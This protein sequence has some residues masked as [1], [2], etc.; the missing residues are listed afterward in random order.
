MNLSEVTDSEL[1]WSTTSAKGAVLSTTLPRVIRTFEEFAKVD[2]YTGDIDPVYWAIYSM[3]QEDKGWATRFAV[4]MLAYYHTGVAA[5]AADYEGLHFWDHLR[6]IYDGAPRASERRHFRG[7]GGLQT[8]ATMKAIAPNPD[9]FFDPMPRTYKGVVKYCGD[10]LFAFGPYFQLKICD[11]MDRCLG[12]P[13]TDMNGLESNLPTLPAKAVALLYPERRIPAAFVITC[14]R[15]KPL[16]LLAP[17]LFDRPLGPAEVETIL[18]DWKRAKYGTHWVGDDVLDKR[19]SL[20]G[21]G[22]M[23]E[24]MAQFM[25]ETFPKDTFKLDL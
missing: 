8:L 5:R 19:E 12:I 11:Y 10:H 4:A 13:I 21:Y 17:P 7:A 14:E 22:P 1:Q 18:C 23:A 25:P 24:Q 15:L 2:V 3:H 16:E 9:R 20:K 6:T